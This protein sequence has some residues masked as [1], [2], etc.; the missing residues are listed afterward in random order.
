[1]L[2]KFSIAKS[3][4]LLKEPFFAFLLWEAEVIETNAIPLAGVDG[5]GKIYINKENVEKLS[6]EEIMGLIAHEALH[7]AL[8]HFVREEGRN[9]TIWNI[10]TDL[11]INSLLLWGFRMT[12]PPG[13]LLPKL[14]GFEYHLSAEKYYS[15]LCACEKEKISEKCKDKGFDRHFMA[16]EGESLVSEPIGDEKKEGNRKDEGTGGQERESEGKR[17]KKGLWDFI[18]KPGRHSEDSEG[19]KRGGEG[20]GSESEGQIQKRELSEKEIQEIE[21]KWKDALFRAYTTARMQ[22]KVSGFL[23]GLIEDI[24]NPRLDWRELLKNFIAGTVVEGVDWTRPDRRFISQGIY[25][26]S[27]REK[28]VKLAVAFDTSGSISDKELEAF[29]G[30]LNAILGSCYYDLL[31]IQCDAK[32]QDVMDLKFPDTIEP[33]DIKMK[34]RGGTD[35]RP[36]FEYLEENGDNRPL[37]YFTDLYGRF[38]EHEPVFP[39]LW[40]VVGNGT[41][42]PFGNI[43]KLKL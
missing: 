18:R 39:V 13:G 17:L 14:F 5:S 40:V 9:R 10:A 29:I 8:C 19:A 24:A 38:P 32:I 37:I 20:Y 12:L 36:V 7:L 1:M 27:R 3:K 31:I 11:A 35:F 26:P 42:V 25:F 28:M 2:D 15:L 41:E 16:G 22:G 21:K 4:L 23:V 6:V 34:G 30:E 43:V 33:G